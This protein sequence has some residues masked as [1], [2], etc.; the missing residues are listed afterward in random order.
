[1]KKLILFTFGLVLIMAGANAQSF[2]KDLQ[3]LRQNYIQALKNSDTEKILQV[4]SKDAAIHHIDGTMLNG[5]KEI[6]DFYNEFFKNSK[7]TIAFENISED[8]LAKDLVFYH[9]KV[10]LDIEGEDVTRNIEV[11]NIA[12]KA[13]GKWRVIKSYRWPMPE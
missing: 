10:F 9:D 3:Q 7:A 12:K 1:M 2:S 4:Y 11:V 8:K 5:S 13:D 6:G